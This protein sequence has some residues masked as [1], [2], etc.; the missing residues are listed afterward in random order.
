MVTV[1]QIMSTDPIA[2]SPFMTVEDAARTMVLGHAGSALVMDDGRLA[3]IF[4]ERDIMH[5]M[6]QGQ[7]DASRASHVD[8]WMTPG[9]VTVSPEASVGEALDLMLEGG[10]RHLVVV[11]GGAVVGV[12]SMRDLSGK[13]A[14]DRQ[15]AQGAPA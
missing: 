6:A 10:F 9:P 8:R 13:M 15:G 12:V 3:G 4:T 11:E 5:A 1:R 7:A 2:I 14:K